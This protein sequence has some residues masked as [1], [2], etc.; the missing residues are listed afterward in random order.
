[1]TKIFISGSRAIENISPLV[2]ER[3]DKML[4]REQTIFVGDADGVDSSIQKYI[5]LKGYSKLFVYCVNNEVRNNI[6]EWNIKSVST[7][8]KQ[9]TR[10]YFT[11]KD[12]AMARDCDF[13]FMI[14]DAK[15]VGTLKNALELLQLNK[16][17]V[18]FINKTE[19]FHV[20]KST[21]DFESLL[22]F[23]STSALNKAEN[24]LKIKNKLIELKNSQHNLF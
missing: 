5:H 19:E 20:I 8:L 9:G 1:M 7:T 21:D 22:A 11:V 10:S 24:K 3:I 2:T 14:W 12:T 23:M 16:S 18:V 6:G 4:D 13:G 17:S 15:S